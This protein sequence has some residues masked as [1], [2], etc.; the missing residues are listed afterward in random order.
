LAAP[1]FLLLALGLGERLAALLDRP[2]AR[3]LGALVVLL[4]LGG[5][6]LLYLIAQAAWYR[7]IGP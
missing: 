6:S 4:T 5:A 1:W 3:L 2:V 7:A